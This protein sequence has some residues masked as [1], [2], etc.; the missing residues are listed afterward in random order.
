MALNPAIELSEL[1]LRLRNYRGALKKLEKSRGNSTRIYWTQAAKHWENEIDQHLTGSDQPGA[2]LKTLIDQFHSNLQ[3]LRKEV[4]AVIVEDL[5]YRFD[6]II[7]TMLLDGLQV[8]G[9]KQENS[10]VIER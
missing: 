9:L 1:K 3:V 4:P 2:Q 7:D 8:A 5:I 10:K 6:A